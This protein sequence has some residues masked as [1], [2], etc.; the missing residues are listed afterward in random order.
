M[1]NETEH[2]Y[3][4]CSKRCFSAAPLD[5][6]QADAP[7]TMSEAELCTAIIVKNISYSHISLM[8]YL[9]LLG[10][11]EQVFNVL[12]RFIFLFFVRYN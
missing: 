6:I 11:S 5:L 9:A 1:G 12:S 3:V 7:K 10:S 2:T 8:I 4:W